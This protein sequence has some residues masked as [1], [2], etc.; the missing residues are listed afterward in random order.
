[1]EPG[2]LAGELIGGA[3][4]GA[5][6]GKGGDYLADAGFFVGASFGKSALDQPFERGVDDKDEEADDREGAQDE[7][8]CAAG[9]GIA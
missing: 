7:V 3:N 5:E 6:F 4:P 9:D 2:V 1:M 8:E